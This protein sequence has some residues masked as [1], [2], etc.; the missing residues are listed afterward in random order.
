MPSKGI[1]GEGSVAVTRQPHHL[2]FCLSVHPCI[3]SSMPTFS[4]THSEHSTEVWIQGHRVVMEAPR[5]SRQA[6]EANSGRIWF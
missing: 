2:S 5:A 3:L 4:S 1:L 6:A